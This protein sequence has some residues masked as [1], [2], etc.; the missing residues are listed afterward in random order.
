MVLSPVP[1]FLVLVILPSAVAQKCTNIG[2]TY[3]T[4]PSTADDVA[5]LAESL[6]LSAVRL[7]DANPTVIQSFTFTNV[8]L[9]LT[10]PNSMIPAIAANR[11]NAAQWLFVHVVPYYPRAR[12]STI[13]VGNDVLDAPQDLSEFVMQAIENIHTSLMREIGI[14]S[15]S[16]LEETNSSF[17]INLYPYKVLRQN[18][19][20]PIGFALFQNQSY[21]LE[22]ISS[23]ALVI[24]AMTA[25]GHE[26][27]R[28][29]VTETGW[30]SSGSTGID[31]SQRK[32]GVAEAYIYELFDTDDEQEVNGTNQKWGIFYPNMT[33]KYD[34]K[35]SGSGG[36]SGNGQNLGAYD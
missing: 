10:I 2:V 23:L 36:F 12:I 20:I 22:T 29:I 33:M 17:F 14:W 34:I 15:I 9:M 7:P 3:T 4:S 5:K 24:S 16:F 31:T 35:L 1:L 27:V 26:N 8:S 28:I 25:S 30:P 13:S 11:S 19:E 6:K 21:N 32:E 18:S